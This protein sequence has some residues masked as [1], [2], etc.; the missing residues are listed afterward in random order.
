MKRWYVLL[1]ALWAAQPAGA[2]VRTE[3]YIDPLLRQ[4]MQRSAQ[5]ALEQMPITETGLPANLQSVAGRTALRRTGGSTRV[6]MFAQVQGEAALTALRALGAEIGSVRNGIATV[7]LPLNALASLSAVNGLVAVEA[8]Q[9]IAINHDSAARAIKVNDVRTLSGNEW[10]GATGRG[11][12]VGVYDTGIDFTHMDF[13]SNSGATRLLALWDQTATFSGRL[14]PAG[15]TQGHVCT[16]EMIQATI[17]NPSPGAPCPQLDTNSHGTHTAGSSAGDGSA[18]GAGG[19][20]FRYTGVAPNADLIIVKGGNGSFTETNIIDGLRWLEA[21]GRR[22]GQPMVVN[23]S[24]GGQTGPHDGSR[25]YEAA[26]DSLSRP[27]FIVVISSGNEGVNGNV[28]RNGAPAPVDSIFIHGTGNAITGDTREFTFQVPTFTSVPPLCNEL[29]GFSF[30]YSGRDRLRITVVRPDN[31]SHSVDTGQTSSNETA[32]G[33]I[34]IDNAST[35]VYP[36]NGDHEAVIQV[37]DCGAAGRAPM[38]GTYR[39]RITTLGMGS[40]TAYHFWMIQNFL[41]G[42]AL[43]RGRAGFD[44]RY[45][46]GSPGNARTAITVGAFTTRNCWPS[47]AGTSGQTCYLDVEQIGDLAR[48]SSGGPTRDGRIKPEITAPGIAVVSS[49]SSNVAVAA[50]RIVPGGLHYANQGTS[51]AAPHVTGAIALLLEAKPTA[52]SAEI[53]DLFRRTALKDAFTSRMYSNELG[54]Q[55]SDWWGFGKLDVPA[56]LCA[57]GSAGV[58]GGFVRVTPALDT[59]PQNATLRLEACASGPV[60]YTSTNAAVASVDAAGNV[61]ALTLG[62]ALIIARSSTAADTADITVVAPS[63]VVARGASAAP[64]TATLAPA[65][66]QLPL[67]Q[68]NLRVNGVEAVRIESLSFALSGT[69]PQAKLIVVQDLNRNGRLESTDRVLGSA[70][71]GVREQN[72]T[73]RVPTPGLTIAQRDSTALIVGV[74]LSGNAPN[75]ADFT[76]S[77]VSQETRTTG[78]RS[79][80]QNR[81]EPLSVAIVSTAARTTVLESGVIFSLSENPVRSS[82][83]TF[84]FTETP[85]AAAIYTLT[86]RR[87]RDLKRL[88]DNTG[89]V[90]WDLRNE[91]GNTVAPGVYLLV[92]DVAGATIRE[93]LF[94][95]TPRS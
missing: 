64:S 27:G 83:V 19:T 18:T 6:S 92:F 76:V 2:Q 30:W 79:G 55:P 15:F 24:L 28:T 71:R 4:L 48:F 54:S 56:A 88:L 66:T 58:S 17:D 8:S 86:G 39:L 9:A 29:V 95:L 82:R 84:N 73:V 34:T 5:Q 91:D 40:G 25:I 13:R 41:G 72:D 68:L 57:L 16:R 74:Q 65:N 45:I 11:V 80:A 63:T 59:L 90:Q 94:V 21:E 42:A 7:E 53:R 14:P 67:L 12:I 81:L 32:G 46:V 26:L 3:P 89:R 33:N 47:T 22:R 61:R 70:T 50:N 23:M 69:D 62:R 1:C 51:M 93:K 49:K 77:F 20:P 60:T 36:R 44:N 37:N 75:N 87:V 10:T 38:P 43:A 78:A 52:T 31:T 35:G 85:S